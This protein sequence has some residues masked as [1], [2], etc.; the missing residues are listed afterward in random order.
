MQVKVNT[1][2]LPYKAAIIGCGMIGSGLDDPASMDK[3]FTHAKGYLKHEFCK[4]VACVDSNPLAIEQFR[5]KWGQE[6]HGY[7]DIEEMLK[8]EKPEIVSICSPTKFHAAAIKIIYNYPS[9][10]VVICEK[11]ITDKMEELFELENIIKNN[12]KVFLINYIRSFDPS[13]QEAIQ[14]SR[15]GEFGAVLG[16]NGIFS[17]GLYHNGSHLLALIEDLFGDIVEFNILNGKQLNADLYGTY[18]VKTISGVTGTLFN[19]VGENYA[20]FEL[21]V[22]FEA[23]RIRFS[24]LGRQIV[25]STVQKSPDFE[26]FYELRDSYCLPDTLRFYGLNSI[27]YAMLLLEDNEKRKAIIDKQL[28]FSKRLLN[29]TTMRHL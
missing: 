23:G 8:I 4:L 6:I 15:S 21:D 16:F 13:H 28:D 17:K 26:G 5:R 19:I 10:L 27:N 20:I 24:E 22:L 12:S 1:G 14:L 18:F 25:I 7:Q 29:F 2:L 11:P 9:V 3:I